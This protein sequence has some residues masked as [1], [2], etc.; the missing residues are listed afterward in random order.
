VQADLANVRAALAWSMD[1]DEV[2]TGLRLAV[3]MQPFWFLRGP[4]GEA[5]DWLER[6]L[7]LVTPP[8]T[9]PALQA[10]LLFAAANVAN[11]RLD[12]A[13]AEALLLDCLAIRR[14]L[15]D[16]PGEAGALSL[17]GMVALARTD[18]VG[19]ARCFERA[20]ALCREA[21]RPPIP[22]VLMGLAIA[23]HRF[24]D[25]V[26]AAGLLDEALARFRQ[27]RTRGASR[28]SSSTRPR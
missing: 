20:L 17:Q 3:A 7:A 5:R 9:T 2:E 23:R 16:K 12:T 10:D 13:R 6:A 26:R 15:D 11:R 21:G 4:L 22:E 8:L 19:A 27:R 25:D 28:W 18:A 1:H 14:S 24:G